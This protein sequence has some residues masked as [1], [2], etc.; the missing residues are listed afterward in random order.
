MGSVLSH[1]ARQDSGEGQEDKRESGWVH[2]TFSLGRS[3]DDLTMSSK[4]SHKICSLHSFSMVSWTRAG[5]PSLGSIG[6]GASASGTCIS[7]TFLNHS[8]CQNIQL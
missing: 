8:A 6:T 5:C 2:R 7:K 3:F 1:R 4:S